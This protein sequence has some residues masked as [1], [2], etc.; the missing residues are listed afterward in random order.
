MTDQQQD[1]PT[2][3]TPIA[4]TPT[5]TTTSL[6]AASVSP[7]AAPARADSASAG[8]PS[9]PAPQAELIPAEDPG[10][11]L[12]QDEDDNFDVDSALGSD[13]DFADAYPS[14]QVIGSDLSPCQPEWVP[15]NV[16]FEVADATLQWPWKDD[17][18]DFVHVRY[19]FG[20]IHDWPA[21]FCEAYRCCAPGG[22]VQS[23][24][25]DVRFH[26]DDGTTDS[27]PALKTWGD[28]FE[29]SGI[30]TGRPFFLQRETIQ[31]RSIA[32]AGFTDIRT[33]DYKVPVGGWPN[34]RR[35]AETGEYVRL[36]LEND[37]EGYT[38]YLWHHVLNWPR[39]EYA[40][41][42][43]SMRKALFN[44]RVH[45]YMMVRYVYGRKP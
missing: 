35:L 17:Y 2:A 25:A 3:L 38:F 24:E 43:V 31:E 6:A 20:A 28:L 9:S 26:C 5:A 4:L 13:A 21:L 22:W 45:G 40:Q 15:P 32:E 11:D 7:S 16:H 42:L 18:F 14:A 23:C 29:Q 19:L 37:L 1:T 10:D 12:D 36:T 41:F 27:E 39:E 44:R 30:E 8:A 34:N 33:F